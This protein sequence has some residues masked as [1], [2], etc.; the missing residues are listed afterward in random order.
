MLAFILGP[1]R[2]GTTVL[3]QAL[4]AHPEVAG[5]AQEVHT[6]HHDLG[7]FSHRVR[8]ADHFWLTAADAT[9]SLSREYEAALTDAPVRLVKV[10][11]SSIQVDFIR[12][13]FPEARF[14]QI[15]RDP[16]D[17]IASMEAL[18]LTFEADQ[19]YPRLLGPA[20]DPLGLQIAE[21]FEHPHL[22][23]AG[24]W[25]FHAVRSESDLRF[26]G[27]DTL[28]RLRYRALVHSPRD[29]L[30]SAL[31]FLGLGWHEELDS[32]V[33]TIGNRPA[34]PS[35]L[36]YSHVEASGDQR[37]GRYAQTLSPDLVQ[38]IAPLI[39][40]PMRGWGFEPVAAGGDFEAACHHEHIPPAEWDA[41][42][43]EATGRAAQEL[44]GFDPARFLFQPDTIEPDW[45]LLE[46][47]KY[48]YVP[49]GTRVEIPNMARGC[50][51]TC[52][53]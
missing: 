36:G 46:W 25:F 51:F 7:R 42:I 1:P 12:A 5:L 35:S 32:V 48:I 22:R 17:V 14:I 11:T 27:F 4:S 8:E 23:A 53:F 6:F 21:T 30:E 29:V 38:A 39:D 44:N 28:H 3:L 31:A 9:E 40:T 26:A 34:G 18:R 20:P 16:L 47:E 13:L 24:A 2:S 52:S 33:G 15:L 37:I 19:E 49:L 45:S 50:P 10:S 43:Q 41:V